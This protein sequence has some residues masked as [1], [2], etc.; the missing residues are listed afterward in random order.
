VLA[1]EDG[2]EVLAIEDGVGA[3]A[4]GPVAVNQPAAAAGSRKKPSER[5]AKVSPGEIDTVEGDFQPRRALHDP[6]PRGWEHPPAAY[7]RQPTPAPIGGLHHSASSG[8]DEGARPRPQN[9]NVNHPQTFDPALPTVEQARAVP[10]KEKRRKQEEERA[11][12]RARNRRKVQEA[13]DVEAVDAEEHRR[14]MNEYLSVKSSSSVSASEWVRDYRSKEE[15]RRGALAERG[16][17][18]GGNGS[19]YLNAR[20]L[21]TFNSQQPVPNEQIQQV[22]NLG[23]NGVRSDGTIERTSKTT[24]LCSESTVGGGNGTM[25]GSSWTG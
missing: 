21:D 15:L 17:K 22:I 2:G 10:D 4:G 5:R 3:G 25:Q 14:M 6:T 23:N 19:P 18:S 13:I 12:R 16:E 7:R 24:E 11:Q 1:I 9:L 20:T 8:S